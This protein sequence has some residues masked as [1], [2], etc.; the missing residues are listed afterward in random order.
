MTPSGMDERFLRVQNLCYLLYIQTYFVLLMQRVFSFL[1]M[2][3]HFFRRL[4][5]AVLTHSFIETP[6]HL[7]AAYSLFLF[8][9]IAMCAYFVFFFF[10]PYPFACIFLFLFLFLLSLQLRNVRRKSESRRV[11][12]V[13]FEVVIVFFFSF[14]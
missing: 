13:D 4:Q 10:W 6:L 11:V 12:C 2:S 9:L 1:F 7:S 8:C 14:L 3:L 5:V